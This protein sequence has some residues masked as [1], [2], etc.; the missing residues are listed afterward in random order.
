MAGRDK[1][2]GQVFLREDPTPRHCL[3]P[4]LLQH[5]VWMERL[6]GWGPPP[7]PAVFLFCAHQCLVSPA[8]AER[9]GTL[10]E[11]GWRQQAMLAGKE[12]VQRSPFALKPC[13]NIVKVNTD[14]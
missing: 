7:A 11:Q 8:H 5:S 12:D 14:P 3:F 4:E 13:V 10:G 2:R 9:Y 1:G 6:V